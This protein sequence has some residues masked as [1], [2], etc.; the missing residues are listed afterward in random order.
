MFHDFYRFSTKIRKSKK[1]NIGFF[2]EA[3]KDKG[4]ANYSYLIKSCFKINSNLS[5]IIQF[6][7][8]PDDL[9]NAKENL[10]NYACKNNKIKIITKYLDYFEYRK[11]LKKIHIVPILHDPKRISQ[12]GSGVIFSCIT[13]EIPM[14]LPKNNLIKKNFDFKFNSYLEADSIEEYANKIL[15]IQGNYDYFLN[16]AKME[17]KYFREKFNNYPFLERIKKSI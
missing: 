1:I 16:Q 7:S 8:V 2:G 3:R 14:I 17:A 15:E 10:L 11:L 12:I 5:F 9:Q 4:F 13:N 6:S